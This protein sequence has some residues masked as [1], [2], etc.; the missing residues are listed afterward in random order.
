MKK[1]VIRIQSSTERKEKQCIFFQVESVRNREC[2]SL[3][4]G[5]AG[6]ERKATDS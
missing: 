4:S 3:P 5:T 1:A 6:K 2:E